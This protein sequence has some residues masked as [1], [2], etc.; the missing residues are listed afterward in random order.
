MGQ[1][2]HGL[3]LHRAIGCRACQ[4]LVE[5]MVA[6]WR[7]GKNGAVGRLERNIGHHRKEGV[8]LSLN[9]DELT[10]ANVLDADA[11]VEARVQPLDE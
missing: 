4:D 8:L 3:E 11:A 5:E 1:H 7:T 6:V 2:E 9:H 10:N